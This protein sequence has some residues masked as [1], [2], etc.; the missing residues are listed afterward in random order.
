MHE[1]RA[2]LTPGGSFLHHCGHGFPD[3][4]QPGKLCFTGTF[5]CGRQPG[6]E[7]KKNEK[8]EKKNEKKEKKNEKK[9]KT[10]TT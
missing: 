2:H 1:S 4:S 8:K 3:G 9:E 10:K 6:D 7:E 5:T